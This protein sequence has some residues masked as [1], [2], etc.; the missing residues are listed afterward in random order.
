MPAN[1]PVQ[2]LSVDEYGTDIK[3]KG[4]FTLSGTYRYGYFRDDV[5][6]DPD[7]SFM[8]D[9]SIAATLPYWQG[10]E[11]VDTIIFSNP[12]KFV[13]DV[14][15]SASLKKLKN[16]SALS[17]TGRI[18]ILVDQYEASIDCDVPAY[19]VNFISVQKN[20]SLA[21]SRYR[22]TDDGC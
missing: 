5:N 20:L 3:F 4:Q 11:Q 17:L 14:I 6:G 22:I 9:K 10:R 7:L 16:K 2:F 18:T 12:E 1:S 19:S 15:P 8:P 21:A 13:K